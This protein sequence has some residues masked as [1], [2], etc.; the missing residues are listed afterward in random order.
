MAS[1]NGYALLARSS[2]HGITQHSTKGQAIRQIP[3][4]WKPCD[5]DEQQAEHWTLNHAHV[6]GCSQLGSQNVLS[7]LE[8]SVR[9]AGQPLWPW[10]LL[11]PTL[12]PIPPPPPPRSGRCPFTLITPLNALWYSWYVWLLAVSH[13][14]SIVKVTDLGLST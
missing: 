3:G 5:V 13:T 4:C 2:Q 14:L 10:L 7:L 6:A 11:L 9:I 1:D 8:L 12:V